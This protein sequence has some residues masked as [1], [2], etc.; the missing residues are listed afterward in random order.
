MPIVVYVLAPLEDDD[1]NHDDEVVARRV[2]RLVPVLPVT[3]T[4]SELTRFLDESEL[5]CFA[6]K[7]KLLHPQA[8]LR[9][10]ASRSLPSRIIESYVSHPCV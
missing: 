8:L 3:A 9:S 5:I 6:P 2:K 7:G 10:D 1:E 4:V